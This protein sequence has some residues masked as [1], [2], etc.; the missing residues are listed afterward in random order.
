MS[1]WDGKRCSEEDERSKKR[2]AE[3]K[4][5]SN[6]IPLKSPLFFYDFPSQLLQSLYFTLLHFTLH[7]IT[8]HHRGSWI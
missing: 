6:T 4:G 3:Y 1:E 2:R 8:L 5:L 7:Y